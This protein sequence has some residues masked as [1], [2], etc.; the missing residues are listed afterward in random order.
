MSPTQQLLFPGDQP[1]R[2]FLDGVKAVAVV[3]LRPRFAIMPEALWTAR[4]EGRLLLDT[5]FRVYGVLEL[6]THRE[7]HTSPLTLEALIQEVGRSRDLV[8][9]CVE[10]MIMVA[11]LASERSGPR[12]T[13]VLVWRRDVYLP[14]RTQVR[15][16]DSKSGGRTSTSPAAGLRE[17]AGR[18]SQVRQPD[19]A[20][21]Y[22]SPNQKNQKS[23]SASH[24]PYMGDWICQNCGKA[25]VDHNG[26]DLVPCLRSKKSPL[27][28]A[29]PQAREER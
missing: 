7:H 1:T 15:Q 29:P 12:L 24:I 18:T 25:K 5:C 27:F 4:I 3:D 23:S 17:S 28:V 11:L 21:N 9:R 10:Q 22:S 13:F 20:L 19:S 16:P 14:G 2:K 6:S 8:R 26:E